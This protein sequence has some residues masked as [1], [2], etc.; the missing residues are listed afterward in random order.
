MSKLMER[1]AQTAP[2][3]EAKRTQAHYSTDSLAVE[4]G[5]YTL[6]WLPACPRAHRTAISLRM[7]GLEHVIDQVEL[8]PH[9]GGEGWRFPD[10]RMVKDFHGSQPFLLDKQTGGIA[11]NDQYNLSTLFATVWQDLHAETAHDFYPEALRDAIDRMNAFI[12]EQVNV[13]I[14]RAAYSPEDRFALERDKLFETW[15]LLEEHLSENRFLLGDT[16]TDA[17]LRLFPNVLR[18]E[19]Y[20]KQF[21]LNKKRLDAFPQLLR[22]TKKIFAIPAVAAATDFA[23]IVETH[24]RS[25]HN[26][27]RFTDKYTAE[28]VETSFAF[29]GQF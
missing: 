8:L 22:Y 16:L 21:G 6:V 19:I 13:Q 10:G 20:Y 1:V 2:L 25:P 9:R 15:E 26:L 29:L 28:T 11:T 12:Y 3:K 5:R 23:A 17:D 7:L 18:Y 4:T 27:A 24:Y 14:Y